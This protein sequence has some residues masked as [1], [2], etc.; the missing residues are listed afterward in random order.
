MLVLITV[1]LFADS[2]QAMDLKGLYVTYIRQLYHPFLWVGTMK[3]SQIMGNPY[4]PTSM[5]EWDT[6]AMRFLWRFEPPVC[7]GSSKGSLTEDSE[8]STSDCLGHRSGA[9]SMG[10]LYRISL[11]RFRMTCWAVFQILKFTTF[12]QIWRMFAEC[13]SGCRFCSFQKS[14]YFWVSR[15]SQ[16]R[17]VVQRRR[18]E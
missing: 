11:L 17:G 16:T 1:P 3:S 10:R 2:F 18:H 15:H 13:T 12:S 4:K 5:Q 7:W 6:W 14:P 9:T 8:S